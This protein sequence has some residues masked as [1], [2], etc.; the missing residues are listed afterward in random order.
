MLV[1]SPPPTIKTFLFID[2]FNIIQIIEIGHASYEI[3]MK[4]NQV[5]Q[6]HC[7]H[8]TTLLKEKNLNHVILTYGFGLGEC[9][10]LPEVLTLL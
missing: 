7:T 1:S 2:L 10:G 3:A 9:A 5:K 6:L 4:I 8:V